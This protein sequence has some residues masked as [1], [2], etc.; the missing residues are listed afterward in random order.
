MLHTYVYCYS[1]NHSE[2][3]FESSNTYTTSHR[4]TKKTFYIKNWDE[5]GMYMHLYT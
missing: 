3:V 2:V 5:K 1:T 4:Y